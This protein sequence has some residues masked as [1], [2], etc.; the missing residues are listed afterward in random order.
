RLGQT[1]RA[2][3][4]FREVRARAP[5]SREV[6]LEY[7][8]FLLKLDRPEAAV[9]ELR[10]AVQMDPRDPV[11]LARINIVLAWLRDE[12]PFWESLDAVLR[13]AEEDEQ[14]GRTMEQEY[15]EALLI[16]ELPSL[17]YAL[18]LLQRQ[19]GRIP[20]ALESFQRASQ[21]LGDEPRDPLQLRLL[22]AAAEAQ[23]LLGQ[24]EEAISTLQKGLKWAEALAPQLPAGPSTGPRAIPHALA[25][26]HWLAEAYTKLGWF[27][28]AIA[29]LSQART[30]HP[31]DRETVTKL[32][33][34]FFRQG[35][36][37]QALAELSG[38]ATHY[39]QSNDLDSALAV[40]QQM[41]R[42]AP[43][44][45]TVRRRLATL[46]IRRGFVD[47]G[48]N[49]LETV[50]ELQQKKGL[51]EEAVR[52]L[53]QIAEIY[54][55]MGRQDRAYQAYGRIVQLVPHDVAARQQLVNLH[56][57]A[58]RLADAL[59]EQRTIARIALERKETETAIAALHQVLALN[60]EDR[61][62][63]RELAELLAVIGEHGQAVRLYR[64]LAR[65]EPQDT[66][67]AARLQ[68]EER[69]ANPERAAE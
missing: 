34:L 53:Q 37:R 64:R 43:S 29:V 45:L 33:D 49:E 39:E 65:L 20:E 41:V 27:D 31:H 52:S 42:L 63:L 26:Y 57:L 23:L 2:I 8:L 58:G 61:W 6:Y 4:T 50:A 66:A 32:A 21:L 38:L 9:G 56:I 30:A 69:Q 25:F 28:Q 10:R 17:Y 14:A 46:S 60:P 24:I 5:E 22:R 15:K 54:W 11:G 13:R 47:R 16:Q 3:E 1:T 67:I 19:A 62:A 55:T 44:N 51:I 36:L 18:G 59:E 48:L 40:L 68:E 12:E 7:G 35:N